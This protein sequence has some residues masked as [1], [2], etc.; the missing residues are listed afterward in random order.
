MT[1]VEL[2]PAAL[3]TL[4]IDRDLLVRW[5]TPP[6]EARFPVLVDERA[7][8]SLPLAPNVRLPGEQALLSYYQGRVRWEDLFP[9]PSSKP[10][11]DEIQGGVET[12]V[13]T[14][15]IL[16][17][18]MREF[19]EAL[20]GLLSDLPEVPGEERAVRRSLLGP[21]SPLA[22][23]RFIR[24]AC[25]E[26]QR[27]STAALFQ[28]LEV[29]LVVARARGRIDGAAPAIDLV[30]TE[31]TADLEALIAEVKGMASTSGALG[32]F[33]RRVRVEIKKVQQ[34]ARQ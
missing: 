12:Q 15:R 34:G 8:H 20:P 16:A 3:E 5:G 14:S 25:R 21:V 9:E 23:A 19:V 18:Q 7:K 4:L 10:S 13:D 29:Q 22:L 24:D 2:T 33:E 30:F 26:G 27:S 17:Y 31:A 28:L 6:Q 11:A 32:T 1:D